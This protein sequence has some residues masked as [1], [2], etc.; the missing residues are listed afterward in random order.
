MMCG[1]KSVSPVNF[2]ITM[3]TAG[4]DNDS[5]VSSITSSI[6]VASGNNMKLIVTVANNYTGTGVP[7]SGVTY[8]QRS[9]TMIESLSH[10]STA[11]NVSNLTPRCRNS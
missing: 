1:I 9:L 3:N 10:P 2:N 8:N 11:N 7:P 6:T 5:S 4:G